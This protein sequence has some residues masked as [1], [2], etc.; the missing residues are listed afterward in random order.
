MYGF[1]IEF[2]I[3]D[4]GDHGGAALRESVGALGESM[5]RS[6]KFADVGDGPRPPRVPVLIVDVDRARCLAR[7]VEIG[8]IF[9]TMQVYLGAD[10]VNDFNAFSRTWR[11]SLPLDPRL[12]DKTSDLLKLKVRNQQGQM[13]GLDTIMEVR[14]SSCAEGD[15]AAQ[16]FSERA[17]HGQS[18]GRCR[19]QGGEV[20]LRNAC[21]SGIRREA[22]QGGL[23][24]PLK[25]RRANNERTFTLPRKGE[26][27]GW[28]RGHKRHPTLVLERTTATRRIAR[29]S[30]PIRR[31]A[32]SLPSPPT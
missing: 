13:V 26:G 7:G 9:N 23:A 4:R 12:R 1:P 20:A 16:L 32:P 5:N 3:E 11:M 21:R 25:R 14:D 28:D 6:G 22:V 27:T 30:G 24:D 19:S 2:A 31:A 15:R 8:E 17:D 29:R 18:R 10:R